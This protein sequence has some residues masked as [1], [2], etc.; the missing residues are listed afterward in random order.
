ME[1]TT[2]MRRY[3]YLFADILTNTV[4]AE[5]PCYG[6]WFSR[7]LSGAGNMTATIAMNAAGYSNRDLLNT[8][9]PGKHA[10]YALCNDTVVWGGPIWSRTYNADGKALAL[11]GQTFES[12]PYKFYPTATLT[13]LDEGQRN[14][15]RSL[16]NTLQSVPL[17]N[18]HITVPP[19]FTTDI[20]RKE[21]FHNYEVQSFGDLIDYMSEY[22]AGFDYEI[23]CELD[24]TGVIRRNLRLGYPKLGLSKTASGLR[25]EYPGSIIRYIYSENASRSALRMLGIGAGEG[26]SMLRTTVD[27]TD[28][29]NS[30][31]YPLFQQV[32]TNKDV[33]VRSTLE[34]QTRQAGRLARTPVISI[35]IEVDPTLDPVLGSWN[36]G[37]EMWVAIEDDARFP[38]ESLERDIR[39]TGWALTP[40]SSENKESLQ[41]TL[42]G[43][44]AEV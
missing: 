32:Y 43:S 31:A 18:A 3:S 34:S 1:G 20:R 30:N 15:V 12:W 11:T 16:F 2:Y 36:L 41:L 39:V 21:T 5:L 23:V 19:T 42:E 33:S 29:I 10:M 28:L 35:T 9:I 4:V 8:T 17:Q 14:I 38:N 24:S 25:F 40:P 26:A 22:D 7:Q 6:T 27:Q 13:F 37:D 44:D